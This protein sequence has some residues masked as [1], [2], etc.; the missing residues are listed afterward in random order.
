MRICNDWA[1]STQPS[2]WVEDELSSRGTATDT[3]LAEIRS[4]GE[5]REG[6][7]NALAEP[8]GARSKRTLIK[9]AINQGG[10]FQSFTL[11]A[12]CRTLNSERIVTAML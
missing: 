12:N 11:A 3:T 4:G 5:E 8:T 1:N 10:V 7:V 2:P 9:S 6:V